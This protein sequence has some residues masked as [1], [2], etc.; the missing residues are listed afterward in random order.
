MAGRSFSL[1]FTIFLFVACSSMEIKVKSEPNEAKVFLKEGNKLK[2]IGVTPLKFDP[3]TV[4]NSETLNL[5]IQKEGYE[6]QEILIEKR[7]LS[8]KADVFAH[9]PKLENM[10]LAQ[11]VSTNNFK[12]QRG[13][14]SIQ[15]QLIQKEYIQAEEAAR[16]FLTENP[17]SAVG[18]NL[19]GNAYLLQNRNS[20]AL[21]SYKNALKYDPDNQ[22]TLRVIQFLETNPNRRGQ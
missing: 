14:A 13:I 9:L 4:S 11:G 21:D 17:Y 20:Q 12:A 10:D 22:D 5:S 18:W 16:N 15:S 1:I 3:Q 2:Q 6:S 7:A 19:L 8:S